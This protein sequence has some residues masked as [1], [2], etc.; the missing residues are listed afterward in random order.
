MLQHLGYRSEVAANGVAALEAIQAGAYQVVFMD[1]QMPELDGV[2]TTRLIRAQGDRIS[3]PFIIAVTASAL[4][5]DRERYLSAGMNT[6]LSKPIS[7]ERITETL[8]NVVTNDATN[9]VRSVATHSVSYSS[10]SGFVHR[11][12]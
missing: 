8:R 5:G 6:Y 1:V 10:P 9:A 4:Q 12:E 3:Q 2:T 11:Q 7:L